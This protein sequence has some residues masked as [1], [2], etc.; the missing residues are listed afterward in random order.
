MTAAPAGAWMNTLESL[1]PASSRHTLTA[2]FS[3][4]RDAS[5]QPAEPAPTI[6]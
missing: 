6:R 3:V 1:A 4:R 5:T 2:G